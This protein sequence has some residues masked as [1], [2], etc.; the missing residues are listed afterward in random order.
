MHEIV[1][2]LALVLI[3]EGTA[4]A[5][6]PAPMKRMMAYVLQVPDAA[7]RNAGLLAV[8][9]GVAIAWFSAR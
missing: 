6:F 4:Y 1:I 3:I 7:L 2:A 5:V 8:L 9:A